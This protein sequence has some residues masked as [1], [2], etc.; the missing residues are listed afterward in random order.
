MPCG[1]NHQASYPMCVLEPLTSKC[2]YGSSVVVSPSLFSSEDVFFLQ[3]ALSSSLLEYSEHVPQFSNVLRSCELRA[4][5]LRGVYGDL[6]SAKSAALKFR[7]QD[8]KFNVF[9]GEVGNYLPFDPTQD[10]VENQEYL[11]KELNVLV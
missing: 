7:E 8:P 3:H 2:L 5:K 10:M 9:V 6:E 11:E 4:F 1:G